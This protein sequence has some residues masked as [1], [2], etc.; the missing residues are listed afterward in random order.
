[1][2]EIHEDEEFKKD[3]LSTLDVSEKEEIENQFFFNEIIEVKS[4]SANKYNSLLILFR[5][6]MGNIKIVYKDSLIIQ[7]NNSMSKALD[8]QIV[9][10]ESKELEEELFDESEELEEDKYYKIENMKL[11]INDFFDSNTKSSLLENEYNYNINYFDTI[12]NE[13]LQYYYYE[14]KSNHFSAFLHLYRVYE[15]V[16]YL[17]PLSYIQNTR[18]YTHSYKEL[19]KFFSEKGEELS[20]L[21][22]FIKK[23][24]LPSD[25]IIDE[26]YKESYKLELNGEDNNFLKEE[27]SSFLN[28]F[29]QIQK[30]K[31]SNYLTKDI[32]IPKKDFNIEEFNT[33][34]NEDDKILIIN[35]MDVNDLLI[36][37]RNK[38]CHLKINH[39]DSLV[40]SSYMFDDLYK[41]M[42]PIFI[43]W[44]SNILKFT[45]HT[46]SK[47]FLKI[48]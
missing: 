12:L 33:H 42:N 1:M 44:I 35:T 6:L 18:E 28:T 27:L 38:T 13:I 30:N 36:K 19:Q 24:F 11:F 2:F 8:I 7:P 43:N 34:L 47:R 37:L 16:S 22:M 25:Y 4:N 17:F 45:T 15:Y 3:F 48:E 41:I 31:K 5:I 40:F 10:N 23:T 20:F 26:M 14:D 39:G 9:T 32:K 29:N 46:S 21:N